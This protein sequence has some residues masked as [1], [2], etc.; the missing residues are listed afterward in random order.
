MK[1]LKIFILF[2]TLMAAGSYAEH[3]VIAFDPHSQDNDNVVG[4]SGGTRFYFRVQGTDKEGY[5]ASEGTP[6]QRLALYSSY[7]LAAGTQK[8]V[9]LEEIEKVQITDTRPDVRY[10]N[11]EL[12]YWHYVG[13]RLYL[14]GGDKP[15]EGI[16]SKF[17]LVPKYGDWIRVSSDGN[18]GIVMIKTRVELGK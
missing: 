2:L 6:Q 3:S 7:D 13:V 16:T 9:K 1:Q 12:P 11:R 4:R 15:I 5:W 8:M 14:K 18:N 10:G 17:S